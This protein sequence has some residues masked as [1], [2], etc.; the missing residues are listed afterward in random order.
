MNKHTDKVSD[1]KMQTEFI[2]IYFLYIATPPDYKRHDFI[3]INIPI[4]S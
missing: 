2:I 3:K 4:F 1:I